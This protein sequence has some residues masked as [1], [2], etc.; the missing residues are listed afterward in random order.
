M[1]KILQTALLFLSLIVY[2]PAFAQNTGG[3]IT[4]R[5]SVVDDQNAPLPGVTVRY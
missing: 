1:R 2:A 5:G 4:I 3:S